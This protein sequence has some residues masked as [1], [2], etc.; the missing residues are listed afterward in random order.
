MPAQAEPERQRGRGTVTHNL[1]RLKNG[2]ATT[3][4]ALNRR[5]LEPAAT[6]FG[7]E[8]LAPGEAVRR[9]ENRS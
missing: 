7:L 2:G 6:R 4:V 3:V 5:D 8:I 9:L 1:C